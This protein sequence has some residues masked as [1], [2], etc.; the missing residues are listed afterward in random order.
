MEALIAHMMPVTVPV[1]DVKVHTEAT[2]AHVVTD[3]FLIH[4]F[5][6]VPAAHEKMAKPFLL[7]ERLLTPSDPH[8]LL[9]DFP[10]GVRYFSERSKA[11]PS[12]DQFLITFCCVSETG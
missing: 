4:P 9:K 11:S 1:V 7:F 8:G 3:H 5:E 10:R 2:T 12:G 6:S